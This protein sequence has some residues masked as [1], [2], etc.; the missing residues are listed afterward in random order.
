MPPLTF[1]IVRKFCL[2]DFQVSPGLPVWK[3]REVSR[4]N[5]RLRKG[6][7]MHETCEFR[8]EGYVL[9]HCR[10]FLRTALSVTRREILLKAHGV[11]VLLMVASFVVLA[12]NPFIQ[13]RYFMSDQNSNHNPSPVT[14]ASIKLLLIAILVVLCLQ[15]LASGPL[16]CDVCGGDGKTDDGYYRCSHCYGTGIQI[17]L[18]KE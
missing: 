5:V 6:D 1:G 11:P 4:G 9:F 10:V 12:A 17:L 3:F 16:Q 2:L 14:L 18:K 7:V 13:W 15:F 8:C